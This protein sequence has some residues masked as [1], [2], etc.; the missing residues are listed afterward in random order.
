MNDFSFRRAVLLR[1]VQSV[2]KLGDH[3]RSARREQ[4]TQ[5]SVESKVTQRRGGGK[6]SQIQEKIKP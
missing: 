6:E 3:V 2:V 1:T 5:K 4:E